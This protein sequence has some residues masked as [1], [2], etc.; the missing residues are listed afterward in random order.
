MLENLAHLH[1]FSMLIRDVYLIKKDTNVRV[2]TILM[3]LLI[4]T[5][6]QFKYKQQL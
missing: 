5:F 4:S 6:F 1:V 2:Y 3:L